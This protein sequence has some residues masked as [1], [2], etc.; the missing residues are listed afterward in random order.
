[1]FFVAVRTHQWRVGHRSAAVLLLPRQST[2]RRAGL[3]V[4]QLALSPAGTYA[5]GL[6][7]RGHSCKS[8]LVTTVLFAKIFDKEPSDIEE[9]ANMANY[10]K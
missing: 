7:R 3:C 9:F 6:C 5:A 1:M 2:G 4:W 8:I 10:N